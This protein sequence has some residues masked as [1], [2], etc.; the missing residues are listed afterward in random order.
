MGKRP[1]RSVLTL[2]LAGSFLLSAGCAGRSPASRMDAVQAAYREMA[3][4][5]AQA[6][7]TAD[8]GQRVYG[9]TVELQGSRDAGAMTVT[10]PENIAGTVLTWSD[11][12]TGLEYEGAEL[13]TGRLSRDGLSPADAMPVVLDACARG[14]VVDCCGETV[15]GEELLRAALTPPGRETVRADCWFR[16]E[17]H[18]LRR[19]ELSQ[20]GQV[21]VTLDFSAFSFQEQSAEAP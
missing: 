12:E 10:E 18:A 7:V 6:E 4:C 21:V 5:T 19:A 20:G 9:Y 15:D 8:Y 3:G 2:M 1:L 14:T 13:D 16:P 11:G 17:D